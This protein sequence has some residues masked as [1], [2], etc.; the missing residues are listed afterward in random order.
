MRY[1]YEIII[2]F[3]APDDVF[4]AEV[5]ELSGCTAHGNDPVEAAR[6]IAD[7]ISLW[8]ESAEEAGREVP[9]P[10]GRRLN[11]A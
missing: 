5:P 1:K 3:S 4:V 6:N 11:F 9:K 2:Y 7:A 10:K 8:I